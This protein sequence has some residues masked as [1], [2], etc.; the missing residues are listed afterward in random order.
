MNDAGGF[1]TTATV[2]SLDCITDDEICIFL[3]NHDVRMTFGVL[4]RDLAILALLLLLWL[5]IRV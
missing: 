5:G 2:T 4:F 3:S 1:I